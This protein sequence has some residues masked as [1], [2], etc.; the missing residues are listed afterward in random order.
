MV[1]IA[2]GYDSDTYGF[3]VAYSILTMQVLMQQL[4]IQV[5]LKLIQ[6]TMV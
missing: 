4:G 6:H 5:I 3:T 2:L 1:G